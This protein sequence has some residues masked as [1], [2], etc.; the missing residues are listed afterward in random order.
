MQYMFSYRINLAYFVK[1][2]LLKLFLVLNSFTIL[3]DAFFPL[4]PHSPPR[5][6]LDIT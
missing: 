3:H 4:P 2:A 1:I 6:R 5:P